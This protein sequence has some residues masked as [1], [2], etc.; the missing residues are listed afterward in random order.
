MPQLS[1]SPR[2][3]LSVIP[4]LTRN[5]VFSR[6][7]GCPVSST[8]LALQ[9]R[10]DERTVFEADELQPLEGLWAKTCLKELNLL[11]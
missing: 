7:Y 4:G 9:V 3:S 8:G 5:P 11:C 2:F 1:L 10:H 6:A